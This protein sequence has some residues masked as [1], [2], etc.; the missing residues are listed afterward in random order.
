MATK[1]K[2]VQGDNLPY[3][4]VT[5]VDRDNDDTPV[6]LSAATSVVVYFRAVGSDTVL[7]TLSCTLPGGGSDGVIRF[8]FPGNT[9]D[10]A[11]GAYEGEIEADYSGLK[12]SVYE[13]LKF[14]VRAQFA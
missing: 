13:L 7:S 12:H 8:N 6:D 5:V 9:L 10:V 11:P 14:S 2:L 3:V 4:D 1:I